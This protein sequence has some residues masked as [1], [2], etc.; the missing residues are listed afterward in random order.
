ML[1]NASKARA[2][3]HNRAYVIPDD[4]KALAKPL[5]VHR[6]VLST[7][8]ELSDVNAG[9]VIDDV[10]DSVTAPSGDL[11]AESASAALSDGGDANPDSEQ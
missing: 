3:I 1:L 10:L 8:A 7:D 5:L 4:I 9:A 2:A 6:L 11:I